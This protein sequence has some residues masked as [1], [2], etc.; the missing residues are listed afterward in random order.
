MKLSARTLRNYTELTR[1]IIIR[2][3][4]PIPANRRRLANCLPAWRFRVLRVGASWTFD[5]ADRSY[6]LT[7]SVKIMIEV[8]MTRPVKRG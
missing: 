6:V 1:D 8:S 5:G 3:L 2:T 7:A 4:R